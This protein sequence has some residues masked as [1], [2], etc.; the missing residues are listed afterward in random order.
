MFSN[1][2][3]GSYVQVIEWTKYVT[4]HS[5]IVPPLNPFPASWDLTPSASKHV[6]PPV[7]TPPTTA[8]T[9]MTVSVAPSTPP[10]PPKTTSSNHATPKM[11]TSPVST[12]PTARSSP[13]PN[14]PSPSVPLPPCHTSLGYPPAAIARPSARPLCSLDFPPFLRL[15]RR[16]AVALDQPRASL[17]EV[18]PRLEA[19]SL[20]HHQIPVMP[21]RLPFLACHCSVLCSRRCSSHKAGFFIDPLTL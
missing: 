2:F 10:T 12:H 9:S 15:R 7:P 17:R 19:R 16:P 4:L 1:A 8:N 5:F 14:L 13:T 18:Q 11:P 6:T 21:W 20:H 3:G